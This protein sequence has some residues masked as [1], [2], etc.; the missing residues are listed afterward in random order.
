MVMRKQTIKRN[1]KKTMISRRKK[2]TRMRY[3]RRRS[4]VTRCCKRKGTRMHCR[5][6][7]KTCLK[8]YKR[9]KKTELRKRKSKSSKKKT[10][11]RRKHLGKKFFGGAGNFLTE[12]I[13]QEILNVGRSVTGGLQNGVYMLQGKSTNPSNLAYPTTGHKLN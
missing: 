9:M 2:G 5:G 11:S 13:P 12:F 7:R 8:Y 10:K 3:N 4:R 1:R 6:R